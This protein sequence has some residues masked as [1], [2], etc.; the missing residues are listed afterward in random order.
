MLC[1]FGRKGSEVQI[2]SHRPIK[3]RALHTTRAFR[4][5]ERHYTHPGV[6][7][8]GHRGWNIL[9]TCPD[10]PQTFGGHA[11]LRPIYPIDLSI[12]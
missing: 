4:F 9:R 12:V 8:K 3:N 5:R 11:R 10:A 2:L 6:D 7:Q 1:S